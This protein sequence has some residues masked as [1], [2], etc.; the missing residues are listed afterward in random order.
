MRPSK[1]GIFL[2]LLLIFVGLVIAY[3]GRAHAETQSITRTFSGFAFEKSELNLGMKKEIK[4]WAKSNPEY[5]VASCVGFTGQNV[6]KRSQTFL[7]KLATARAKNICNYIHRV[8]GGVTIYS[9]QGIPGNGKTA[10]A[11]RVKV[12]LYKPTSGDGNSLISVGV[13]DSSLNVVMRSRWSQDDFYFSS[14]TIRD[15]A[16]SCKGNVLDV[17]LLDKDG[18]QLASSLD[19]QITKSFL[20]LSF[21]LFDNQNVP[22]NLISKV[23]FE[24]RKP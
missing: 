17:Y 11:R 1:T 23:A 21:S 16:S 5:T 19:N 22:S 9:T 13:C 12:T 24:L 18:N 10:A 20:R 6:K 15:I 3:G 7:Q 2:G 4:E 8:N 14:I